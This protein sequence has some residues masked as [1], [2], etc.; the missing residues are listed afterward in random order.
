MAALASTGLNI[1]P[2]NGYNA[3]AA[4]GMPITL[5]MNAQNRFC[6]MTSIVLRAS[7]IADATPCRSLR[8]NVT[9]LASVRPGA[10]SHAHIGLGQR[11]RV[12]DPV[13]DHRDNLTGLA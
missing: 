2:V 9:S 1:K 8:I 6:F 3:P 7:L 10:D 13:S 4:T 12:D 11:R 5:K